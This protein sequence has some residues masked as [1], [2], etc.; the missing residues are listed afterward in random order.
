MSFQKL[1]EEFLQNMRA[2]LGDEYEDYLRSF[3]AERVYGLRVNTSK[4]SPEE[5]LKISP[6]PLRKVPWTTDGFYYPGS[7]KPAK[8]PYY[9]AGL[10]YLQ[11]PSAMLPAA[12]LPVE[13]GDRIL[14]VCAAPG[15]KSTELAV[16]LNR[17]GV[18]YSNDISNSRAQALLKNLEVFGIPNSVILSEDPVKLTGRFHSYFDKILID[19]PC[20]GEGMFRKEPAVIRSWLEHGHAFYVNLQK[21]ITRACLE[22]LKPGGYLLYSTCTFSPEEDENMILYMKSLCPELTVVRVP[23]LFEGFSEGFPDKA[24]SPDPELRNCIRLFP[25]RIDGEGHFVTLLRKGDAG[26]ADLSLRSE[27]NHAFSGPAGSGKPYSFEKLPAEVKEFLSHTTY[28]FSCGRFELRK[29]R[30]YFMPAGEDSLEGLRTLRSGLLLGECRTKR[31]E[32]SQAF[33]MVLR[34]DEFRETVSLPLEDPRVLKYLKGETLDVSELL[35]PEMTGWV[36]V[37]V[38]RFPLGFAKANRGL[39]KNHYLPGWRYQ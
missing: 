30:L 3:D 19:A 36:L 28:D 22:M 8:H 9:F 18:L 5:F 31:F 26:S 21:Q 14:D 2:L 23:D 33:A 12:I 10:Y 29:D 25:H 39:L 13:E 34:M 1:P 7:E 15:G 32:P 20:S 6:F 11:E 24:L 38:G 17:K 37:C 4:I 16:R 27:N 35:P